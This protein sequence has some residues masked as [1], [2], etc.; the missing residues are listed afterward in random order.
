MERWTRERVIRDILS[1]EATGQKLT[2]SRR[3]GVDTKL[4]QAAARVFGSWRNAL[5]AAGISPARARLRDRWPREKI[6][7]RIVAISQKQPLNPSELRDKYRGLVRAAE[8][9]FGTWP[10]AVAAAGV[11]PMIL[12][13]APRWTRD[14]VVQAILARVLESAP[15]GSRT[16][17]PRSLFMAGRRYFG[18]WRAALVAAGVPPP[19]AFGPSPGATGASESPGPAPAAPPLRPGQIWTPQSVLD[20]ILARLR[21]HKP[22]N[23]NAVYADHRSLY[24]AGEKRF[25]NWRKALISAGLNP[26]E[27]QKGGTSSAAVR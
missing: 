19:L 7:A 1:R 15:L 6:L 23:A 12:R 2:A 18:S 26:D 14:G 3:G 21:E 22:L 16:V 9:Q 24:R 13:R 27:Y 25:G 8:V 10:K 4:Y 17:R 20:A 11:A 5:R